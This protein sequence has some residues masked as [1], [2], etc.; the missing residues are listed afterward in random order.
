[1]TILVNPPDN[2]QQTMRVKPMGSIES[3]K[4]THAFA[5]SCLKKGAAHCVNLPDFRVQS[6]SENGAKSSPTSVEGNI[7]IC[8]AT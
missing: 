5:K 8:N 3:Q 1:M 6:I 2:L 7:H 4:Q